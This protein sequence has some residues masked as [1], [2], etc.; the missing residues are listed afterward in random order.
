MTKTTKD[1]PNLSKAKAFM[2]DLDGT[3]IRSA[4]DFVK[5]KRETIRHLSKLGIETE[6]L[7]E[8]MRT[9]EIMARLRELEA[10]GKLK[11]PYARVVAE[12]TSVWDKVELETVERTEKIPGVDDALRML[13]SRKIG[14]GV[15]TRGCRTY[16]TEALRIAELLPFIDIIVGRDDVGEAKPS[17][18]P[19]LRAMTALGVGPHET[20]MVG[21]TAED[22]ACARRAGVLFVGVLTGLSDRDSLTRMG[23]IR[24]LGSIRELPILLEE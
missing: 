2:F 6:G 9:Y 15:I 22:A 5:L 10:R 7:S 11:L 12:V 16:A 17:P 19:L 8:R 23:S 14:V 13:K 24:V 18:E 4:V 3:L 1:R 20:V 21:D